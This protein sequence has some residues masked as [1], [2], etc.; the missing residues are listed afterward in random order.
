L[1]AAPEA[2][3]T[4]LHPR[5]DHFAARYEPFTIVLGH[6][7]RLL[8]GSYRG[9][10]H[11]LEGAQSK[12]VEKTTR[13]LWSPVV[14]MLAADLNGDGQEEVIGVTQDQRLFVLNGEDLSDIWNTPL[15]LFS[16]IKAITVGD[17]DGDGQA[18]IIMVADDHL[19]F[20]SGMHNTEIWKSTETYTDT[21]I[22][23][24]DVTGDGKAEIVLASGVVMGALFRDVIW[25]V[26][27]GF[28]SKIDLF[29]IDN[30]GM[31]E[32]IGQGPDGLMRV[33][34]VDE[35]RVKFN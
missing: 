35:R 14:R 25:K 26:S 6:Q 33:F 1:L 18:D 17:V 15:R 22:A 31:L 23:F 24:G 34:D 4:V 27:E 8:Y 2:S 12:L 16:S 19:R 10:L 5:A 9:T 13:D 29:D 32:I 21:E 11:L 3:A 20:Y 28:G 30:D 7:R